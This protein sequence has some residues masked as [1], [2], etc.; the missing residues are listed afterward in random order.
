MPPGAADA[1]VDGISSGIVVGGTG[2]ISDE[3]VI[4]VFDLN[5]D[6]LIPAK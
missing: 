4:S 5:A 1:Y 2:L 6:I 3:A